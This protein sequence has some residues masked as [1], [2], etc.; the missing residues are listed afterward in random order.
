MVVAQKNFFYKYSL[1]CSNKQDIVLRQ[2]ETRHSAIYDLKKISSGHRPSLK[3]KRPLSPE[4]KVLLS[5]GL[6]WKCDDNR[7]CDNEPI[8]KPHF[9]RGSFWTLLEI[10]SGWAPNWKCSPLPLLGETN[11]SWNLFLFLSLSF[12]RITMD[13]RD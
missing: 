13:Q 4:N 11:A 5:S 3:I 6:S 7:R 12:H 8:E 2:L 10:A 1:K 9:R